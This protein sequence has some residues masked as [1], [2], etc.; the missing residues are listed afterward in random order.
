[1]ATIRFKHLAQTFEFG[2][3]AFWL[4]VLAMYL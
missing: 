3:F 1:L 4:H 2:L